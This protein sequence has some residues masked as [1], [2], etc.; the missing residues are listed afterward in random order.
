MFTNLSTCS[1]IEAFASDPNPLGYLLGSGCTLLGWQITA[2]SRICGKRRR[3]RNSA[4]AVI[5]YKIK[6]AVD[7]T[8]SSV[9][10][11]RRPVSISALDYSGWFDYSRPWRIFAPFRWNYVLVRAY[12]NDKPELE[13]TGQESY[14]HQ[15]QRG[16]PDGR[17]QV[18]YFP[19]GET[20]VLENGSGHRW[21]VE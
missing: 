11:A 12:L 7:Q 21:G 9:G 8:E 13:H 5:I 6:C 17:P 15:L 14:I 10:Y 16:G 19:V 3:I 1:Y 2:V 18:S 4:S 20:G